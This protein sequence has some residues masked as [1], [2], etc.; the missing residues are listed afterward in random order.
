MTKERHNELPKK[1]E[2]VK[3]ILY[4]DGTYTVEDVDSSYATQ[5][6]YGCRNGKNCDIYY[7]F[8]S[9]WKEYLVRLL[10]TNDIDRQIDELKKKKRAKEALKT[11]ILKE[12]GDKA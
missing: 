12:M 9:R 1:R 6:M 5:R 11:K 4:E 7:C 3:V 8:K 2:M 10:S